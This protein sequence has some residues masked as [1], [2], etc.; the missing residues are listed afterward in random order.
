MAITHTQVGQLL[1]N[2]RGVTFAQIETET[3]VAT[4]AK[5]KHMVITKRTVANVQL[6]NNLKP[7]T[8][9]YANAVKRSSKK[10]AANTAANVTEF[11]PSENYF[12]HTDC[13]SV[14]KHKSNDS[15][16]LY[17]I[18]NRSSSKYYINGVLATKAQ[19]AQYLTPS[20]ANQLLNPKTETHNVTN[21]VTHNVRCATISFKNIKRIAAVKQVL[22]A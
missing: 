5:F 14:V 15:Y 18:Y 4:S 8:N 16:Y 1:Q 19:V 2:V 10:I 12:E 3:P 13:Y 11:T 21:D 20:A 7:G 6:F 22:H 9:P 17:A